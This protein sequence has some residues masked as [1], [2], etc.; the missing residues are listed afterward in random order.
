M[1][2]G[3]ED[4]GPMA[5]GDLVY[6]RLTG[7][8]P[9]GEEVVRAGVGESEALAQAALDGLMS[10]V[11]R[12]RRPNQPYRSRTATQFLGQISDYDHLARV[13]EWSAADEEDEG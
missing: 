13:R 2:G 1:G 11:N 7:R 5:P 3:F 8:T 4:L 12:Y 9:P 10:L 6:L